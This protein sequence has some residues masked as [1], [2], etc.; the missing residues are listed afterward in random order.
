MQF[1]EPDVGLYVPSTHSV[2][3]VPSGPVYPALHLQKKAYGL[4]GVECDASGQSLHRHVPFLSLYVP[5][6]HATH[7]SPSGP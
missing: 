2:Q 7:V 1:D 3:F 5:P 4:A 6:R